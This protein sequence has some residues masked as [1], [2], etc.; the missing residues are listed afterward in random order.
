MRVVFLVLLACVTFAPSEVLSQ[1]TLFE[2]STQYIVRFGRDVFAGD[3]LPKANADT[4]IGRIGEFHPYLSD[5]GLTL[6]NYGLARSSQVRELGLVELRSP[7]YTSPFRTYLDNEGDLPFYQVRVPV[8]RVLY[9]NGPKEEQEIA[10]LHTQNITRGLNLDVNFRRFSSRG[11]YLRQKA[12]FSNVDVAL[13]YLSPSGRYRFFVRASLNTGS[14]EENGG[15]ANDTVFY[16]ER[17]D[18]KLGMDVNLSNALNEFDYREAET[19]HYIRFNRVA[20]ADSSKPAEFRSALFFGVRAGHTFDRYIDQSPTDAYYTRFFTYDSGN[21]EDK[22]QRFYGDVNVGVSTRVAGKWRPR[23]AWRSHYVRSEYLDSDTTLRWNTLQ[24]S[25]PAV[26]SDVFRV[27]ADGQ[28]VFEGYNDGAYEASGAI[29]YGRFNIPYLGWNELFVHAQI[30]QTQ[31]A[32]DY[33]FYENSGI[34]WRNDWSDETTTRIEAGI[35]SDFGRTGLFAF[36]DRKTNHTYFDYF[37][38]PQQYG[39]SLTLSGF[40]LQQRID[41]GPAFLRANLV[42]QQVAEQEAP[43]NLPEWAVYGTVGVQKSFWKRALITQLGVDVYYNST[44][45][46]ND[47]IPWNR[48]FALQYVRETGGFIYADVHLYLRIGRVRGF[49]KMTN[50]TQGL[51]D[52]DYVIVPGYP[53][54]DRGLRMGII[55]EFLN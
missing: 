30:Q 19:Q 17:E 23:I 43:I 44:Y 31:P 32:F 48:T 25:L 47:Y 55:W 28:L 6:G 42:Y 36:I 12:I 45:F 38:V 50:V 39:S 9:Y 14:V 27:K 34:S 21:V 10:L 53:L 7:F 51:T 24:V 37:G 54:Q 16:E 4:A 35:G 41:Y 13:N 15:L 40:R 20:S 33:Q 3:S 29:A 26:R 52:P 46:A 11:F 22:V 18:N 5:L 1:Q 8:T 2:D 49:V